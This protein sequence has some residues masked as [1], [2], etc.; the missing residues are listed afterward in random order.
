M[1]ENKNL[2][3]AVM[4]ASAAMAMLS[5]SCWAAFGL[6]IG[7]AVFGLGC[8][9]VWGGLAWEMHAAIMEGRE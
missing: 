7:M 6:S 9:A 1:E 2:S 3:A 4:I 8:C 5:L